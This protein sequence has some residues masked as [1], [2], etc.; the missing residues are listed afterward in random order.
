MQPDELL[1]LLRPTAFVGP[2]MVLALQG[3]PRAFRQV[4]RLGI[5]FSILMFITDTFLPLTVKPAV[6]LLMIVLCQR[7]SRCRWQ[8][9]V[10]SAIGLVAVELSTEALV[11]APVF[12]S[13][14][15]SPDPAITPPGW[16]LLADAIIALPITAVAGLWTLQPWR[17]RGVED[18][19]TAEIRQ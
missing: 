2:W 4:V 19:R 12:N 11:I 7:V 15:V 8:T 9:A 18:V 10:L 13:L 6:A 14:G 5:V 17:K 1:N 16:Y 3:T